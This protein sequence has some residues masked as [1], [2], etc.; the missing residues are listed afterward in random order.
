M[1]RVKDN[2]PLVVGLGTSMLL[3]V[4]VLLP[5]LVMVMTARSERPLFALEL[6]SKDLRPIE[7]PEDLSLPYWAG[8]VPVK[9]GFGEPQGDAHLAS[10]T[11]LPEYLVGY[12]RPLRR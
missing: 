5:L 11:P 7:E 1:R 9:L 2:L 4:A 12:D 6:D 8:V 3:H 10:G